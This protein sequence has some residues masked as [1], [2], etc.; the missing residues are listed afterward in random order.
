M[1][2]C[3]RGGYGSQ[4]VD[5]LSVSF[6]HRSTKSID[7][8]RPPSP[9]PPKEIAYKRVS[10][11]DA[12]DRAQA[13]LAS[14]R[15]VMEEQRAITCLIRRRAEVKE[16]L[17][18]VK[19]TTCGRSFGVDDDG[20]CACCVCVCGRGREDGCIHACTHNPTRAAQPAA[21]AAAAGP[22][23]P[24]HPLIY[25]HQPP[26]RPC[27]AQ[28]DAWP[29]SHSPPQN[30]THTTPTTDQPT[31]GRT[32]AQ[33]AAYRG[34]AEVPPRRPPAGVAGGGGEAGGDGGGAGGAGAGAAGGLAVVP[35]P[36]GL[37]I[38][39]HGACARKSRWVVHTD[40]RP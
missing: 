19:N 8:P 36:G 20:R 5:R 22:R 4:V 24:S 37:C 35:G 7:S 34:P 6:V 32:R 25:L 2:W 23:M 17:R 15:P 10:L 3:V 13:V 27:A 12:F 26:V 31:G 28:M 29:E 40:G 33:P 16:R 1:D 21:A 14:Q 30:T 11:R 9:P 38:V 39:K 18:Q